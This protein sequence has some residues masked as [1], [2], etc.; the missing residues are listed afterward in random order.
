[1]ISL[2]H[3]THP[4]DLWQCCMR[5]L[6]HPILW[7][8]ALSCLGFL[9]C[10][11]ARQA[12]AEV[13]FVWA[14]KGGARFQL[15]NTGLNM[16]SYPPDFTEDKM[17][18]SFLLGMLGIL[19]INERVE[20]SFDLDLGEFFLGHL[21]RGQ[22]Q[23]F[24]VLLNN[25]KLNLS[26]IESLQ[27]QQQRDICKEQARKQG[28][29]DQECQ[30]ISVLLLESLL[31]RELYMTLSLAPQ[32][33]VKMDLGVMRRVI[34]RTFILDNYVIGLHLDIDWRK[35]SGTQARPYRLELDVFLPNATWTL[36]GKSSPTVHLKATYSPNKHSYLGWFATYM[37]DGNN[38]A[39]KNLL[40][41]W[42]EFL[43]QYLNQFLAAQTGEISRFSCY[44]SPTEEDLR[45]LRNA[46][47]QASQ[48]AVEDF[49]VGYLDSACNLL[50]G[51][52]GHHVWL[53]VEGKWQWR[54]TWTLEGTAIL[55]L[56][57]MTIDLP[58]GIRQLA[59]P[60]TGTSA[61]G[62]LRPQQEQTPTLEV[63]TQK[64][65]F[66]GLSFLGE[67]QLTY[68][69]ASPLS[70]S[71][72]VLVALGDSLRERKSML[73]SF[74]GIAPQVRHTDIFFQGGINA[75][76][77][78]RG[79]GISG[80]SGQGYIAPGLKIHYLQENRVEGKVTAAAF[81]SFQPSVSSR[82]PGET[83]GSFYGF[84][85]NLIGSFFLTRWLKPVT[86]IDFFVPGNFFK[87]ALSPVVMF[88]WLIGLDFLWL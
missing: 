67:L 86:Q 84:E 85:L 69:W 46:Y 88:Q 76:S 7:F 59:T 25:T 9:C 32:S 30:D 35:R 41:V 1:M 13:I 23:G 71:T 44:Q 38:L 47:P 64:I 11:F 48:K 70:M 43:P 74:M 2:G 12:R 34:G 72:F 50:P 77:S 19:H 83:P 36:D 40:P 27:L 33:W 42:K 21:R 58:Q 8:V 17:G 22:E 82:S 65:S 49:V 78:R 31:I 57:S 51:S 24:A 73:H 56:S 28:I 20:F 81:W 18:A 15:R 5:H 37:Y 39:G 87:P 62:G 55:Y 10:L 3:I 16:F 75:Y 61:V 66:V 68:H 52:T 26:E 63:A 45:H 14:A 79:I 6:K 53:G 4:Q 60:S 54:K 29:S 80:I